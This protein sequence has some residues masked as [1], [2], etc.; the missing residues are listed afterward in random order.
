MERFLIVFTLFF[1]SMHLS[2]SISVG[3]KYNKFL[4]NC[5]TS[6]IWNSLSKPMMDI[7][8]SESKF[9]DWCLSIKPFIA[10]AV[11]TEQVEI[12]SSTIVTWYE[13]L[14]DKDVNSQ[15]Q[16]KWDY[17]PITELILGLQLAPQKLPAQSN[18]LD[19][20]TKTK[21]TSI[22]KSE[23]EV[24]WGGRSVEENYHSEVIDQRFA[25]DFVKTVNGKTFKNEGKY[26][27]DYFCFG[28][29][30]FVP[31]DG[32]VVAVQGTLPDN[33]PGEMDEFNPLGNY[34]IIDHKNGE[35]SFFAHLKKDSLRLK[36]G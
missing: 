32:M 21:L 35:F 7:F 29:E 25:Y 12:H 23:Y 1:W 24:M 26:N 33:S 16:L 9:N 22:F 15:L 11:V 8:K 19:Y 13:I 30:L 27:T 17:H 14:K 34:V 20:K 6:I 5:E 2:A 31:G 3:L 36:V 18:F 28:E 10:N 4:K